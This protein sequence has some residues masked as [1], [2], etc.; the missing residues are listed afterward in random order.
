M[1]CIIFKLMVQDAAIMGTHDEGQEWHECLIVRCPHLLCIH[2]QQK[3]AA[4]ANEPGVLLSFGSAGLLCI[5]GEGQA[6]PDE[7][8]DALGL[9]PVSLRVS[10]AHLAQAEERNLRIIIIVHLD[11]WEK[12]CYERQSVDG[13]LRNIFEGQLWLSCKLCVMKVDHLCRGK[14]QQSLEAKRK[15]GCTCEISLYMP[16]KLVR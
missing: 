1:C 7:F 5:W 15:G 12:L 10:Q 8:I 2:I 6:F 9:L 3:N 16:A 14:G 4:A 11:I 13:A